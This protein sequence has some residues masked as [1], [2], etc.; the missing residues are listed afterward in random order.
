MVHLIAGVAAL[1]CTLFTG[2]ALY[3]NLVEHPARLSGDTE[4]A[5]R[6]WAPS[7]RR[8]A[9]MQATL[10]MSAAATGVATWFHGEGI[11][12]L[13]GG[14]LILAVVPFTLVVIRPTNDRLLAGG[15]DVPSAETR[16]LLERWG[17]LHAVRTALGLAASIVYLYA[18][19]HI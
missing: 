19:A 2:A 15:R 12:W 14:L 3:M 6:Q 16:Q 10:A 7:Y 5:A 18:L 13:W 9:I 4:A 11:A 8:A 17:W 1:L